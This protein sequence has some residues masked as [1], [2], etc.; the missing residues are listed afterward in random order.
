M[1]GQVETRDRTWT[2]DFCRW[3]FNLEWLKEHGYDDSWQYLFP[4][5]YARWGK[6][7]VYL[8]MYDSSDQPMRT[9]IGDKL[10][11]GYINSTTFKFVPN[12]SWSSHLEEI[13]FEVWLEPK[14]Q[15]IVNVARY[16]IEGCLV[17][18]Y[19]YPPVAAMQQEMRSTPK[20][21]RVC[22]EE[23]TTYI[24]D[25]SW[26]FIVDSRTLSYLI[27]RWFIPRLEAAGFDVSGGFE[28]FDAHVRAV[29]YEADY[30]TA[31]KVRGVIT[32]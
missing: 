28:S 20:I 3:H 23:T 4:T 6:R 1:L 12:A 14:K 24:I 32:S 9:A 29:S 13:N 22:G 27:F 16:G 30:M 8:T 10:T 18:H 15:A 21:E 5:F 11:F 17:K 2:K 25:L 26:K 19:T 31:K 7:R